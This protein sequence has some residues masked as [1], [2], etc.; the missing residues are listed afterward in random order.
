MKI[1][2]LNPAHRKRAK[3]YA[4]LYGDSAKIEIIVKKTDYQELIYI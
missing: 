1:K 2:L 3:R 4:S